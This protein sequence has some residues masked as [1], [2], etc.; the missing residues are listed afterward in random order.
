MG[1]RF[2]TCKAQGFSGN[3]KNDIDFGVNVGQVGGRG[4]KYFLWA[5][6][7]PA[8]HES[9]SSHFSPYLPSTIAQ[10]LA[11]SAPTTSITSGQPPQG[12]TQPCAPV[13]SNHLQ[14][15]NDALFTRSHIP[16]ICPIHTQHT[17][18]A[19]FTTSQ[20]LTTCPTQ[21]QHTNVTLPTTS[22]N[23]TICPYR[24]DQI[25]QMSYW[26][27]YKHATRS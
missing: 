15:T 26:N 22:H 14:Q 18:I 2:I 12:T 11:P 7:G 19:L 23:K 1:F 10:Q 3:L 8:A 6:M 20:I 16:T 4:V 27:S 17:S 21:C 9:V 24:S 25:R 13:T 5:A